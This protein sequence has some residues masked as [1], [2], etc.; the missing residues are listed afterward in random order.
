MVITRFIGSARN[1]VSWQRGLCVMLC[2]LF[3]SRGL[4]EF[5]DPAPRAERE[6][7]W[8]IGEMRAD[9]VLNLVYVLNE[10]DHRVVAIDTET[11]EMEAFAAVP[12]SLEGGK[13][14]FSID[15]TVIYVS[16]P[17][18]NTIHSF[19]TETLDYLDSIDL[20][21]SV[22]DFVVGS[23]GCL[24]TVYTNSGTNKAI[25]IDPSDGMTVGEVSLGVYT[26]PALVV[27]DQAGDR[28]FVNGSQGDVHEFSVQ[29]GGLPILVDTY[30]VNGNLSADMSFDD[31]ETRLFVAG[32][33]ITGLVVFS[34]GTLM[35]GYWAVDGRA[36]VAVAE[37]PGSSAVFAA[38]DD[39]TIRR[40]NKSDGVFL[41]DYDYPTFGDGFGDV[42]KGALE[43][44]ANGHVVYG[45]E[46]GYTYDRRWY[47][48]IIGHD[49][50][51]P[52]D[53]VSLP[54]LSQHEVVTSWTVG[55]MTGDPLRNLVYVVDETNQK[56]IAYNTE[57]G[58]T[59]A[60]VSLPDD[61]S[62][63]KLTL[64]L[65]NS[66]L[67]LTT[68]STSRVHRYGLSGDV[69]FDS[70]LQLTFPAVYLVEGSDGFLYACDSNGDLQKVDPVTGAVVGE[71]TNPSNSGTP[72]IRRESSGGRI[73]IVDNSGKVAEFK[74]VADSLPDYLGVR[75]GLSGVPSDL[76]IDDTRSTIYLAV[77]PEHG[78]K[79]WHWDEEIENFWPYE[80][81][82]GG[83]IGQFPG[84]DRI[85]SAPS[86]G[87][88]HLYEKDTG[89]ELGRFEHENEREG[90]GTTP[91]LRDRLEIAANEVA[92]YGENDSS[93]EPYYI[94]VIGQDTIVLPRC[95]PRR[96]ENV[97]A[98]DG[99]DPDKIT[100]TW[101]AVVGATE[102]EVYRRTD[103]TRPNK[104]SDIPVAVV[105]GFTWIDTTALDSQLYRY[106]V[107]AAN[108]F[109]RSIASEK[110][111][112]SRFLPEAPDAPGSIFAGDGASMDNV[113]LNWSPVEQATGYRVF[114]STID[115][116]LTGSEIGSVATDE[117]FVDTDAAGMVRYYYWVKA[118]NDG[119]ESDFSE[120]NSGFRNSPPPPDP[121]ENLS[122]TDGTIPF[123]VDLAWDAV[124]DADS[125]AVYR[126]TVN[127]PQ[128]AG[129]IAD[130][131]VTTSWTDDTGEPWL[132][133]YYWVT[134]RN[135][136]GE[137]NFSD[138]DLGFAMGVPDPVG[139][140]SASDALYSDRI[141][142]SWGAVENAVSYNVYRSANFDS[143]FA[144]EVASGVNASSWSDT[145]ALYGTVY[146]YWIKG[147]NEAG[148]SAIGASDSGSLKNPLTP[149]AGVVATDGTY[150]DKVSVS[151]MV[152]PN[153]TAYKV[154]RN[155]VSN[156]G[157]A[158]QLI[159]GV[160]AL[161]WDD[162]SVTPG[163][164]YYY[165]V[166]SNLGSID[167]DFGVPDSGFAKKVAG[168]PG[169]LTASDGTYLDRIRLDWAAVAN[170]EE[171]RVYRSTSA[172]G[173]FSIL[174][175]VTGGGTAYIDYQQEIGIVYHYEVASWT[176]TGG[177]STSRS[178]IDSG[179]RG[180][181][182][183]V[184][185]V[186]SDGLYQGQVKVSWDPIMGATG[187]QIFRG[188][189]S[190]GS[191]AALIGDTSDNEYIDVSGIPG[192]DYYYFIKATA[193]VATSDLGSGDAG[194][195][196]DGPPFQ[197]DGMI[198]KSP[199]AKLG[200]NAYSP[201]RQRVQLV[202]KRARRLKWFID[203]ENDGET[204]DEILTQLSRGNR[205]FKVKLLS[206]RSGNVTALANIGRLKMETGAGD[207]ISYQLVC[208][209]SKTTRGKKKKKIFSLP[210][211]SATERTK[212][213]LIQARAVTS[214]R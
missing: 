89:I 204:D 78:V 139:E 172:L 148:N 198:G 72:I 68:P 10:T 81:S 191:D 170:A 110:E 131:I 53:S 167:S 133:Y 124:T 37:R 185:V 125:Y 7:N 9:P 179:Y 28:F 214:K 62:G 79:I 122:A 77:R 140:V 49:S 18:S 160:T 107:K 31:S 169:S 157:T 21:Y 119:G 146:Y 109:G 189:S 135:T 58:E 114:R 92:V 64:S 90:T 182:V 80:G 30:E 11:G 145:T 116:P 6:V 121:P 175:S 210:V 51:N 87:A 136:Y 152:D 45:R 83:A 13:I 54:S 70:S 144:Q 196:T 85:F 52:P 12:G 71:R 59:D 32:N 93:R 177:L 199:G 200:N 50:I 171:Y 33:S 14:A 159:S 212:S 208:K 203:V 2:F 8:K 184:A 111:F 103:D 213:D 75:F 55:D 166:R 192:S 95:G 35:Q 40:F 48:G 201:V 153:A 22:Y 84:S 29:P 69:L 128:G 202:S 206:N 15:G 88:I 97:S 3:Y 46:G 129:I 104:P 195:G 149:P 143:D 66:L 150:E 20:G 186:A 65:D 91:I 158:Q 178:P 99:S 205:L 197:P 106:W 96:P 73:F 112:G 126:N 82:Y 194:R 36:L 44:T 4:A 98:T 183:P 162:T 155:T 76:S 23:D 193:G 17:R 117:Y 86:S 165:W 134:A 174:G 16:S 118:I 94:G 42:I 190:D 108:S 47:L 115:D 151:W 38:S 156:Q 56:L 34:T 127:S 105:S 173:P 101:D 24:Y 27:R 209:P 57:S 19:R 207:A 163:Q 60:D 154:F 102:Y 132:E 138:S 130:G 5:D 168:P 74:I 211:R 176:A 142:V 187:Y 137:G 61:P 113:L 147:T 100:V 43:M 123:V 181:A 25:K 39:G 63:G 141:E 120:S 180:I 1:V 161:S 41:Y 164:T 26:K 67:Y 188:T